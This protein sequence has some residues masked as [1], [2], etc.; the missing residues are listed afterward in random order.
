MNKILIAII[1]IGVGIFA[2]TIYKSNSKKRFDE[3]CV[4]NGGTVVEVG[5][6]CNLNN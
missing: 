6:R 1:V 2:I 5:C 3:T 4:S